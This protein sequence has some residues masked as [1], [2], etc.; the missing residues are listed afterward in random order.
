VHLP[1]LVSILSVSIESAMVSVV[2][3]KCTGL[4]QQ[5]IS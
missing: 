2:C 4:L 1:S 3:N 5:V